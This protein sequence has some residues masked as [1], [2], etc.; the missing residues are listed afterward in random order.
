M[1]LNIDNKTALVTASTA[2][3]GF[4]IAKRLAKENVNVIING[5]SQT[6]VNDAIAKIKPE[7]PHAKLHPFVG[8]LVEKSAAE[9]LFQQYPSIDILVN[10]LGIYEPIAF[11]KITD[12]DWLRIFQINVLSGVRL[13]RFYFPKMLQE[14]WGRVIFISSESGVDIPTEMIHYG[15]TKTAQLAIARGMAN[16]TAHTEVTVNSILVGP[17]R[18]RGVEEFIKK[19]AQDSGKS[20]TLVEQEFFKE[21]RPGSLLNR[22]IDPDEVAATVAYFCSALAAATNGAALRSEGGLLHA[23]I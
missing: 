4:A 9:Q 14:K 16:L 1:N 22:F 23:I 17:T 10:N 11:E 18:S 13:A 15:M 21:M 19:L 3:I 2:G 5:R 8:D 20:E 7:S 12:E 6:G